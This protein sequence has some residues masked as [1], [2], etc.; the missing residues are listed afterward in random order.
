[1]HTLW[2]GP[3]RVIS[4]DLAEYT[5]LDLITDKQIVYH[6]TQL[7]PFNF[8]PLVTNPTDIA[9]RDYLEF[10]I[11]DILDMKGNISQYGSL[12]FKV[13][14]LNYPHE[15]N[16]WEPWK[17]LRKAEKLHQFLILKNL[18]HLIPRE[19]RLDYV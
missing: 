3:L 18:Q 19:F 5:L 14:W 10:F 6:M 7:K 2:R 13:K 4:H 15:N 1:M 17:N 16:T 12:Q 8:D 11:E 9:R